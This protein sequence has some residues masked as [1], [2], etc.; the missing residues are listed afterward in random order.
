MC[1]RIESAR[2][3]VAGSSAFDPCDALRGAP[4][5]WKQPAKNPPLVSAA[6]RAAEAIPSKPEPEVLGPHARA[7]ESWPPK[8]PKSNR[9]RLDLGVSTTAPQ[10]PPLPTT[11]PWGF[12][13]SIFGIVVRR[14]RRF[15]GR[16]GPPPTW[17]STTQN[18]HILCLRPEKFLE[19]NLVGGAN[20]RGSR[21]FDLTLTP[22]RLPMQPPQYPRKPFR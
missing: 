13:S 12:G 10:Q 1:I 3:A 20:A 19:E 4:P 5:P 15:L 2:P 22:R 18:H 7:T 11:I 6:T 16:P 17:W 14:T 9:V 21:D 8:S